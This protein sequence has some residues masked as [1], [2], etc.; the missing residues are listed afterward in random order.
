MR[1]SLRETVSG[2]PLVSMF[3]NL[4]VVT[5]L[6][7]LRDHLPKSGTFV[8]HR[9]LGVYPTESYELVCKLELEGSEL[10]I[11]SPDGRE[12]TKLTIP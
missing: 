10:K 7:A 11:F 3:D 2:G 12:L 4:S 6:L 9:E 1:R 8:V 5:A